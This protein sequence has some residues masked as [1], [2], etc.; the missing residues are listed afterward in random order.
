MGAAVLGG[1]EGVGGIEP[2]ARS[3]TER[4]GFQLEPGRGGRPVERRR[5]ERPGEIDE[6]PGGEL[7]IA[8][9]RRADR[10]RCGGT[11][12]AGWGRPWRGQGVEGEVEDRVFAPVLVVEVP[13]LVRV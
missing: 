2:S 9:T 10:P 7:E 1:A 6:A 4:Q 11:R 8:R 13:P 12:R 5:V 3:R